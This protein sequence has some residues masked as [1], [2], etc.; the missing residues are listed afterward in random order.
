MVQAEVGE[1]TSN[2]GLTPLPLLLLL[3]WIGG[4]YG[5]FAGRDASRG[6]A[7]QSFDLGEL[8]RSRVRGDDITLSRST[9]LLI[10]NALALNQRCSRRSTSP[11]TSSTILPQWRCEWLLCAERRRRIA[12]SHSIPSL[13]PPFCRNNMREWVSHFSSKYTVVGELVNERD[14]AESKSG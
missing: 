5:N 3:L 4:P 13:C 9:G 1:G 10:M 6:M 11:W 12:R 14:E 2:T 7:K 8:R